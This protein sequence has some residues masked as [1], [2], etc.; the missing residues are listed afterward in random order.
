MRI[1]SFL[2][3][4]VIVGCKSNV[5]SDVQTQTVKRGEFKVD[6]TE[7]GK[8]EATRALNISSPNISYRFGMLKITYIV[9]DGTQVS[10]GDTV[11]EFDPSDIQKAILDAKANLDIAKAN[12]EKQIS[13]NESELADLQAD[14]RVTEISHRISEIRLEQAIYESEITK[15]EIQLSLDQS[16]IELEKAKQEIK[17]QKKIQHEEIQKINLEISQLNTELE[18]AHQ[19]L[20]KLSIT[21]PGAGIAIIKENRRT[22]DKW[23]VGDQPWSGYP[24][25]NLPDL[26]QLKAQA[27]VHEVDISKIKEG[28]KVE[29]M[30][31]AQSDTLLTGKVTSIAN[32]A[33]YK[34]RNSKIKVFPIEILI[35]GTSGK[36]LPGITVSCRILVD[37]LDDVLFVPLE[38]VFNDSNHEYVYVKTPSSYEKRNIKTGQ[39]NM[40]FVVIREGIKEGEEVALNDPF[41]EEQ[42]NQTDQ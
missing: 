40:D 22:N 28:Q 35:D 8:V 16:K 3:L 33:R 1:I 36:L 15:K 20:R 23:Q 32:L 12:L 7:E 10:P 37:K 42:E 41:I 2:F 9:E 31:D 18:E 25:I 6:I 21:S 5:V 11:V 29:I 38:S 24:L 39:R 14:L 13:Q 4:A 19:T 27:E 17:N 30:L 34:N 26:T